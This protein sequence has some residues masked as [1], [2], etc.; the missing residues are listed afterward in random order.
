[1]SDYGSNRDLHIEDDLDSDG[2][3]SVSM[4]GADLNGYAESWINKQQAIEIIEHLQSAFD[5][6][7][8]EI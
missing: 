6:D 2:D 3:L 1:M 5:I 7:L 8:S 4:V